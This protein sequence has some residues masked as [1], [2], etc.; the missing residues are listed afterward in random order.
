MIPTTG[1]KDPEMEKAALIA[2]AWMSCKAAAKSR[3]CASSWAAFR[4][5]EWKATGKRVT[6]STANPP[7]RARLSEAAAA[8]SADRP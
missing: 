1:T 7:A 4:P 3:N 6:A 8:A 5:A 2:A